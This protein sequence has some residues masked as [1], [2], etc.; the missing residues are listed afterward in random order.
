MK[1][2]CGRTQQEKLARKGNSGW[3]CQV[4]LHRRL[5]TTNIIESRHSCVPGVP[6]ARQRHGETLDGLSLP[7]HGEEF[8]KDHGLQRSVGPGCDPEWIEVCCSTGSSRVVIWHGPLFSF[9]RASAT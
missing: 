8:P 2:A 6:V 4:S 3:M 9:Q 5:A 1:S 7:G